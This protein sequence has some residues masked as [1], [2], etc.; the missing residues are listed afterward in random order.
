MADHKKCKKCKK[1][2]DECKCQKKGRIGWYGLDKDDDEDDDG[3]QDAPIAGGN[4]DGGEGGL[5]E[6]VKMPRAP[7]DS[8]K[9]MQG[10]STQKKRKRMEDFRQQ[11]DAAKKRQGD[12]DRKAE[13]AKER[14]TKGIRF[15]DSKGSGY[16]RSGKKVYD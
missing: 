9:D 13:L 3:S 16:I 4:T 5:G 1:S 12:E 6:Q 14:R 15:Y 7:Q 11:V 2:D 10:M 8:D